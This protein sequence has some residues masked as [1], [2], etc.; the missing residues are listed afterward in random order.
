MNLKEYMAKKKEREAA[1]KAAKIQKG[2]KAKSGNSK[3]KRKN[4]DNDSQ[5]N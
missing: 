2:G 4:H 1:N 5:R 3:R